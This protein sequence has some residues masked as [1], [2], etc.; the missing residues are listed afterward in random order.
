MHRKLLV[1][2]VLLAV[3][4]TACAPKT[5]EEPPP[6][7]QA[8]LNVNAGDLNIPSDFDLKLYQG[9]EVYGGDVMRVSNAFAD[10]KPVVVGF[11]AGLCPTCIVE[12]P[13]LQA[14]CDQYDGQ[15]NFILVDVGPFVGLG[16]EVDG[17]NMLDAVKASIPAGTLT[18]VE[19]L[20]DYG[21]LG[22]PSAF[23]FH[24]DGT[25]DQQHAGLMTEEQ[26]EA[27]IAALLN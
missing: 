9:Q 15:V 11:Y 23:F 7:V 25:L 21:V 20:R 8:P 2:F 18:S 14:A 13:R 5:A 16:T 1:S 26:I 19:P 27:A 17:A 4:V 12:L 3:L 22:T 10:G 6:A 24:A